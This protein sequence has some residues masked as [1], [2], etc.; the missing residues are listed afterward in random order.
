MPYNGLHE[1]VCY[2]VERVIEIHEIKSVWIV[3]KR[4]Y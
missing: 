4:I 3:L 2:F 1:K